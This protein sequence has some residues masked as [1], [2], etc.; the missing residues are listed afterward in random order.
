MCRLG[1]DVRPTGLREHWG[2]IFLSFIDLIKKSVA[3][4]K[5]NCFKPKT[6]TSWGVLG[7]KA[8]CFEAGRFTFSVEVQLNTY[9]DYLLL[10]I[11]I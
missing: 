7:F 1:G 2:R 4:D 6:P 8:R 3:R 5:A 9:L 11:Y 10:N